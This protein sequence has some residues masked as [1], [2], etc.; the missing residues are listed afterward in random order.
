MNTIEVITAY[1]VEGGCGNSFPAI[2]LTDFLDWSNRVE[3]EIRELKEK[4]TQA[5]TP[6]CIGS[7]IIEILATEGI[8]TSMNGNSVIA[9]DDLFHNSPYAK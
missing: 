1:E 8:W 9:A 6:I 4:L 3:T 5:Q 7:P 2:R